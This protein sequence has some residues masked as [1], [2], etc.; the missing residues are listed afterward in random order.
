M[1]FYK[2]ELMKD[3]TH[4]C[5]K[6][7]LHGEWWVFKPGCPLQKVDSGPAANKGMEVFEFNYTS[8]WCIFV[9]KRTEYYSWSIFILTDFHLRW[10]SV[11]GLCVRLPFEVQFEGWVRGR[12]HSFVA[13][14]VFVGLGAQFSPVV[15]SLA[16]LHAA[17]MV[18]LCAVAVRVVVQTLDSHQ[19]QN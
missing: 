5:R 2:H 8:V 10:E 3:M 18:Q 9:S 7:K 15:R 19:R 17:W 4:R 11:C 1:E 6:K 13:V 12:V 14:A 16:G